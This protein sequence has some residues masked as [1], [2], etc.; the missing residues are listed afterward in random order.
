MVYLRK[1]LK[2]F[3]CVVLAMMIAFA[4][5]VIMP[6]EASAAAVTYPKNVRIGTDMYSQRISVNMVASGDIIKNIKVSSKDLVARRTSYYRGVDRKNTYEI[7]TV[8]A[9]KEGK[10]KLSFD[11]FKA[12]GKKRGKT[13]TI[14]IHAN[15]NHRFFRAV[16]VNNTNVVTDNSNTYSFRTT[17]KSATVRFGLAEGYKIRKIE[18]GKPNKKGV[19]NYKTVK[20]GQKTTFGTY[21]YS[22]YNKGT[23]GTSWTKDYWADTYFRI[24]Y[25]DSYSTTPK[26]RYETNYTIS[27]PAT[28]WYRRS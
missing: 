2:R 14:T 15:N 5:I 21:A 7:I 26:T 19:V 23:L 16:R 9:K 28:R 10:Y 6:Q 11:V 27:R 22:Y 20:N 1:T 3:T 18:V 13:R 25:T 8:Y 17:G 12:N 24:T 4:G